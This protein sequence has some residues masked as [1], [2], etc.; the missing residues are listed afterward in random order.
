MQRFTLPDGQKILVREIFT[1][2]GRTI[3]LISKNRRYGVW[4]ITEK[5]WIDGPFKRMN[6]ARMHFDVHLL[7]SLS[8]T[9]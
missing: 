2:D 9:T 7:K 4:N 1:H 8:G 6:Q 5:R 3:A